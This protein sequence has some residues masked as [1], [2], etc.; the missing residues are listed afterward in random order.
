MK[1]AT[2]FWQIVKLPLQ[3][4][5]SLALLEI[6]HSILGVVKSPLL[7]SLMQ[8]MSR[9]VLL[10]GFTSPIAAAHNSWTVYLMVASWSTVEVP[11][12]LFYAM[13]LY[14]EKIPSPLFAL[15]YNMFYVL[16][17]TGISGELLQVVVSLS[18][19]RYT[20]L[21]WFYFAF[22]TLLIYVPG[23][24]YMYTHM[25]KQRK[26]AYEK[27]F[28]KPI[29]APK[30]VEFPKDKSGERSSTAVNQGA[31]EVCLKGVN[32]EEA[33]AVKNEKNWRF[34]YR[35][36]VVKNT[37]ISLKS[38]ATALKIATQGLEYLHNT[39]EFIRGDQVTSIAEAMKSTN[40][41]FY[42]KT[43]KGNK[44]KPA[45]FEY[46][47]PY[48]GKKLKGEE[49]LKQL[50]QWTEYGTIEPEAEEAI[51]NMVKNDEILDLSD[52]Y[53]VLLGAGSAM[54]PLLV[55][56]ALG[57]N[58]IAVDLDRPMIWERLIKIA[59]ESCG[60]MTFPIKKKE[61]EITDDKDL[62]ANS[63]CNL[64]TDTPEIANW[65]LT[66][67]PGQRLNIGAYAYLDGALFV[68]VSIAMDAIIQK[69]LAT[70]KDAAICYLCSPTDVFVCPKAAR[71]AMI[72]NYK[73]APMW[74]KIVEKMGYLKKNAMPEVVAEDGT[75]FAIVDGIVVPQ[76]P[77]YVLAKRLQHWRCVL[78][79]EA[80]H[81]VSTNI[82]PSTA[83]ASVVSNKQFAAAYG[84]M[85]LFKPM[86]VMY[87][88]T[89][90][91]VMGAI[92][93]N[94]MKNPKSPANPKIPLKN[95]LELFAY[96]SFHGSVIPFLQIFRFC[97]PHF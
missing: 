45:K 67:H 27:R 85:Y 4:T 73:N 61:E 71:D 65:L 41:P 22:F 16:Y 72:E 17:P 18:T 48:Q 76:G 25:M 78:S 77:N 94:D 66:V 21:G 20:S 34:G 12:Y 81:I 74:Q 2:Q 84:G 79:R 40:Q 88:E 13:N 28:P 5:Q 63:G 10:W 8:V 59:R 56:M 57:A 26:G 91:A 95:Q 55:L 37:E 3:I 30:G 19:L 15:R 92:L 42:T 93:I 80:G 31:F 75:K 6:A 36:H 58:V 53:F 90:N 14:V 70:R 43:I 47:I 7:S 46:E 82:A 86:E 52:Q 44:P 62:F 32:D 35:K 9:I 39:F 60:T 49:L 38:N 89:S 96:N 50:R 1:S 23:A 83:T 69:V 64:F 97:N 54:G 11:R 51:A 24:P 87:Q 68:K 29:P 33:A